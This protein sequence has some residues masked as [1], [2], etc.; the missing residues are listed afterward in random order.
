MNKA[1]EIRIQGRTG[2]IEA[3]GAQCSCGKCVEN[4]KAAGLFVFKIE[5]VVNG[6]VDDGL[7]KILGPYKTRIEAEKSGK[8]AIDELADVAETLQGA[9]SIKKYELEADESLH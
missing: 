7:T 3:T 2:E 4:I 1:V 6:Y 5:I 8:D 9:S